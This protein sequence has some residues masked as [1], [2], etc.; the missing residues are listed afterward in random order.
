LE[1]LGTVEELTM[2]A[3]THIPDVTIQGSIGFSDRRLKDHLAPAPQEHTL[4]RL[5]G[6]AL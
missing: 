2:G 1:V 4:H 3:A 6:L 5:A